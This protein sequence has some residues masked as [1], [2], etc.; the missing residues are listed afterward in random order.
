[1]MRCEGALEDNFAASVD[2]IDFNG[3]FASFD[4]PFDIL[5]EKTGESKQWTLGLRWKC[6]REGHVL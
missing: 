3:R 1:M 6:S 4:E 2:S 5:Q